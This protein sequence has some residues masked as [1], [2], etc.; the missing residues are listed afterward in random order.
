[1]AALQGRHL[2]EGEGERQR[3][4][5]SKKLPTSPMSVRTAHTCE[6][7][8]WALPWPARRIGA[9]YGQVKTK[10]KKKLNNKFDT[11]I[12]TYFL[13]TWFF[14]NFTSHFASLII[15]QLSLLLF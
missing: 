9:S 11:Q 6:L 10:S 14:I 3:E 12:V 15:Y 2:G 1:M 7:P 8:W 4:V 5:L 13:P